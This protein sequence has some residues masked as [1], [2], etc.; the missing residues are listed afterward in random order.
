MAKKTVAKAKAKSTPKTKATTQAKATT[1]TTQEVA[2]PQ[3]P[4][5]TFKN[6]EEGMTNTERLAVHQHNMGQLFSYQNLL[7]GTTKID[8]DDNKIARTV[9]RVNLIDRKLIL[10]GSEVNKL[11]QLIEQESSKKS[12]VSM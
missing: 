2:Q 4:T 8:D 9:N 7:I 1:E 3:R 12:E 10:I 11:S 5:F 6:I